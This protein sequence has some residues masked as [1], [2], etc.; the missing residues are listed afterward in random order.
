MGQTVASAE[1]AS[2]D[3]EEALLRA[4]EAKDLFK[5][6]NDLQSKAG[7]YVVMAQAYDNLKN[8]KK[9][10]EIIPQAYNTYKKIDDADGLS[11]AEPFV[12]KFGG[13]TTGSVAAVSG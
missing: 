9:A 8:K 7:A 6:L 12:R 1:L 4:T 13:S 11:Y 2:G 5:D 10:G 3:G